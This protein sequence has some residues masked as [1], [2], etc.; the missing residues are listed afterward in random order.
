MG[1]TEAHRKTANII[2]LAATEVHVPRRYR[3][4]VYMFYK[5]RATRDALRENR[6]FSDADFSLFKT[7]KRGSAVHPD[8]Y[9]V[10]PKSFFCWQ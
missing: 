5:S 8:S 6:A 9:S 3:T 1:T 4:A 10:G 2:V 7:V